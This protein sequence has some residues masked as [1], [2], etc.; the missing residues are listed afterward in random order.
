MKFSKSGAPALG[1]NRGVL[2]PAREKRG[3]ER[4]HTWSLFKELDLE[5]GGERV[6]KVKFEE[7]LDLFV[8]GWGGNLTL[9][10]EVSGEMV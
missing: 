6:L 1:S 9:K 8:W 7:K 10:A 3:W 5:R 2:A 4:V